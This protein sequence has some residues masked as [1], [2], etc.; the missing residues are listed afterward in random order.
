HACFDVRTGEAVGP[1]ALTP[2]DV[3]DVSRDGDRVVVAGKRPRPAPSPERH[4]PS[5]VVVV[6]AGAVGDATAE[7]LRRSGYR[8]PVTLVA[9]DDEPLPVDRPNLSKDY[10]DGT[11]PE[12]WVPLRTAEFYADQRITLLP[13]V[14]VLRIDPAAHQIVLGDGRTLDYGALVLATGASPIRLDIPGAS[15][16]H[17]FTLRTERDAHGIIARLATAKRAVV[18]GSSFIGLEAAA[19]LRK[20]GLEVHVV[21]PAR[22][23][24]LKVLGPELGGFVKTLHEEKGVVFHLGRKPAAIHEHAVVLDNGSTLAAELVV[25]GVG[26]RPNTA[27]AEAAGLH[28]DRG[29]VVDEYLRTS[30]PDVYA[31]G[32][33]ARYPAD[34]G[35][36]RIEHWVLAQR[37]AQTLARNLLGAR[38]RFRAVPFFWSQHY[39]VPIN[40]TGHAEPWDAVQVAGSL[41]DRNCLIA[42]RSRARIVAVASIYRDRD[43]LRAEDALARNDQPALEQLMRAVQ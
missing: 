10:L 2:I 11:A 14:E 1:P 42:Y 3:W 32:D 43:C 34:G 26:V 8:E 23:P 38:E 37:Q 39:D 33:V 17:V 22:L 21:S 6:G 36:L 40:Y 12:A 30:A 29:I 9:R 31:A 16:P 7:M 20:R 41:A 24:L 4:G 25:M 19:S 13:R 27:L 18:L 35:T 28:V 5:S 15:L